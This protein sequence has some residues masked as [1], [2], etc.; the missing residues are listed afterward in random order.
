MRILDKILGRKPT[1]SAPA[2][3]P[4]PNAVADPSQDPN[5]IRVFDS[6]GRE[7]FVTKEQ[8]RTNVLPGTLQS[9][10]NN[11]DQL[12]AIIVGAL[13]DGLRADIFDAARHLYQI[14]T[15]PM[16]AACL[17]GIVLME[18]ER[19]DDAEKVFRNYIAL[20]GEDGTILTNLAKIFSRRKND[21]L[22]EETLWHAL[23]VDPNQS[24]GLDWYGAIH[25]ERGGETAYLTAMRRVATLPGSWRAQL[26]IARAA[27]KS[28]D[29]QTAVSLYQECLSRV[30][31]PVPVDLLMQMSGDLGNAGQLRE[32]LQLV[33]PHFDAATH[34]LRVGN[35]LIKAHV[36]LREPDM[37][38]QVLNQLFALNRPDYKE[39]LGYWDTEIAKARL[40]AAPVD[41]QAKVKVT[42]LTIAGP[43]WLKP[44]SRAHD[45]FR[46][47]PPDAPTVYFLGS[48]AAHDVKPEGIQHQLSDASGRLSRALPLFLAEQTELACGLRVNTLI[49]WVTEPGRGFVVS[50]VPWSDADAVTYSAQG[51]TKGAYVVISHL[52]EK[53][54]RWIATLRVVRVAD[55]QCVAELSESFAIAAPGAAVQSLARRFL[56]ALCGAMPV[57]RQAFLPTYTT[58]SDTTL[59][60]YLLRLEQLLATRC[61][62]MPGV[63]S[64]F[65]N[66]EREIID[67]NIQLCLSHPGSASVR[68]LLAQT[69]LAMKRVRPDVVSEFADRIRMLQKEHPLVE[70]T[71]KLTQQ[72]FDEAL[73]AQ[74]ARS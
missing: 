2:T 16:R 6:Y 65:L 23:E 46:G 3:P 28:G 33:E 22:A 35:N 56:D 71:Q 72:F 11:P 10:W 30:A 51:D 24:N 13:N 47:T 18:E 36:E 25:G 7:L 69:L 5:L 52:T 49:P 63:P 57:Q 45:L 68:M 1:V 39:N 43:I 73:A 40:A 37:A 62:S 66:G 53:S 67:G 32:I 31:E 44:D 61:A 48:S 21:V 29:V 64:E 60:T 70:P 17:W 14:D 34:G 19:L 41:P 12:Y 4:K 15:Q 8:W 42:L 27:L 50:G 59:P 74:A 55:G 58:I 54:E 9:N 26:Q 38:R 20:H